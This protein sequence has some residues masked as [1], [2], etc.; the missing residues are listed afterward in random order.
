[1]IRI[2][3]VDDSKFLAKGMA[4]TLRGLDFDVVGVAHDGYEAIEL[5]KQ[6]HPEV[7]LLDIT[8]PNMDGVECLRHLRLYDSDARVV[9]LSAI[10][11][12]DTIDRCMALGAS[13]FL[14]KPIRGSSPSDLSRLCDALEVAAAKTV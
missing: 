13:N 3:L 1:M 5:Y 12:Q 2:L 8:M 9:M 7:T 14:Q 10:R 6:H 4:T 11:D